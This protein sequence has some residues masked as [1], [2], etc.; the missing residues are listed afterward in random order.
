MGKLFTSESVTEGH[1]DKLCDQI[2][3]AILDAILEKDP[4][5]RVAVET[6]TTRGLVFVAGEIST[7]TY[8]DIPKVAREVVREAGYIKPEYGFEYQSM[9]V[10][11]SIQEQSPDIAVG[12]DKGG[13]GDQGLMF[14]MAVDETPELMPMPIMLAHKL[15]RRLAEVRKNGTLPYL[16]PD[17]KSQVTVEYDSEGK[18]VRVDTVII[19]AQH[20]P[21]I[22]YHKLVEDIRELVINEI[23]PESMR[24]DKTRYYVNPTG[25]FVV[26]GPVGDTGVTGRKIMVDTYGGYG[27]HGGGCFSGKD[28]SKVDRSATYM[29]RYIAKNIVAARLARK[30]EV[31]LAYAIGVEEPV[32]IYVDT[33][34]TSDIPE[35][36]L[37][38]AIRKRFDLTPRGIIKEL[39]LLR[40]V[41]RRTAAYGHFGREEEGFCWERTD[42]A[43]DLKELIHG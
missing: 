7:K 23:V 21:G 38:K 31:Q 16:R 27:R 8:V 24:D 19:S 30:V 41:Y 15:V 2:S 20:D 6:L 9:A 29:A 25:I 17:G 36:E 35:E 39:N 14:G 10:I 43:K 40:P 11:S 33:F 13:A 22:K 34:G 4:Q 28:P 37:V 1:P 12:V 42:A 18:P 5:G 26:G 32:A 3:D